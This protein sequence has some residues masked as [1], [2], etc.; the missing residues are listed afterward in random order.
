LKLKLMFVSAVL[1]AFALIGPGATAGSGDKATGGGQVLLGTGT[2]LS[3]IAFTAQQGT[4]GSLSAKGQVQFIDRTAGAGQGQVRFHGVVNCLE[5]NDNYATIGGIKKN[6]TST[7]GEFVLRVVD[8]GQPNQ[9]ADLIQF[10]EATADNRCGDDDAD[11]TLSMGLAHGN[12]Q[13]RDGDPAN[14]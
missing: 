12:A 14:P 3:T 1:A 7:V 11:P 6:G 2:K 4:T 5:V 10:D 13:V 9:G 8:N